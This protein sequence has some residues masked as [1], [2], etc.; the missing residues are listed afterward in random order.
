[1]TRTKVCADLP[2][3]PVENIC[4]EKARVRLVPHKRVGQVK[5]RCITDAIS[6]ARVSAGILRST[7]TASERVQCGNFCDKSTNHCVARIAYKEYA[8]HGAIANRK[9][10]S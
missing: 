5:E 3:A 2:N 7:A 10:R 1:M 9:E 6:L 4:Y 8:A